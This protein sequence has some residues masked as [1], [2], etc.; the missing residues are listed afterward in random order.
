MTSASIELLENGPSEAPVRSAKPP[1][2]VKTAIYV[3]TLA[4]IAAAIG[5]LFNALFGEGATLSGATLDKL[6]H[7][8]LAV[9]LGFF[10]LVRIAFALYQYALVKSALVSFYAAASTIAITS[11]HVSEALTIS[12]GAEHEKKG[13]TSFRSELGRLLSFSVRCLHHSLKGEPVAK[14]PSLMTSDDMLVINAAQH[15]TPTLFAVKLVTKLISKQREVGRLDSALCA[16]VNAQTAVMVAA[17]TT[18]A[19]AKKM[20]TPAAMGE[21]ATAWLFGF[22]F[23]VPVVVASYT[24]A[25]PWVAPCASLFI[26]AFF[27]SLNE[28]A[29]QLE[30]ISTVFAYDAC[31]SDAERQIMF[32][33]QLFA[34]ESTDSSML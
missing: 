17:Y 10:L 3:F 22:C 34:A 8:V 23:T 24:F 18:I 5:V 1:S 31:V 25:T 28:I 4:V 11:S 26:A 14:D 15:P 7:M 19:T 12:A 21:F 27:F 2:P 13:L 20:P 32:D 6:V 33:L 16:E 9:V 30:D 29:V